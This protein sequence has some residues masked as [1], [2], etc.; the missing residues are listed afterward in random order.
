MRKL[1][2]LV[3]FTWPYRTLPYV[4][5]LFIVYL[6]G[7]VFALLFIFLLLFCSLAEIYR[8]LV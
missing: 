6:L 8:F 3:L 2:Y 5:V 4:N 1:T 7:N